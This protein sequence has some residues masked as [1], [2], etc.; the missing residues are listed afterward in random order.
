MLFSD[1]GTTFGSAIFV[2]YIM[3]PEEKM[4]RIY[5]MTNIAFMEYAHSNWNW[6]EVERVRES[7]RL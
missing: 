3:R 5:A 6:P 2:I 7:V 1:G 4:V